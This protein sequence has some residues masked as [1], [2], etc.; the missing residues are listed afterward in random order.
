[1][2]SISACKAAVRVVRIGGGGIVEER[3]SGGGAIE[4]MPRFSDEAPGVGE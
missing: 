3:P 2:E 4:T 1:M